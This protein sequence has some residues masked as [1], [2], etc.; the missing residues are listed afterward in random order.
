MCCPWLREAHTAAQ[1]ATHQE[2]AHA[3]III[4]DGASSG[5]MLKLARMR[6]RGSSAA[7]DDAHVAVPRA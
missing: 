7:Q 1:E 6:G 3:G 5:A 2:K 4:G